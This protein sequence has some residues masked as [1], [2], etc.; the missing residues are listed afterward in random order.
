MHVTSNVSVRRIY[1]FIGFV[2]FLVS[3]KYMPSTDGIL[4]S[5]EPPPLGEDVVDAPVK[6]GV[7]VRDRLPDAEGKPSSLE[8]TSEP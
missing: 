7:S 4:P 3:T 5:H 6:S 2:G 1:T 8:L